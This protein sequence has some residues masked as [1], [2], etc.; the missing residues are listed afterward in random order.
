M[1]MVHSKSETASDV[2][3]ITRELCALVGER[4]LILSFVEPQLSTSYANASY[5]NHLPSPPAPDPM[6]TGFH[7]IIKGADTLGPFRRRRNLCPSLLNVEWL[8]P[9]WRSLARR[10]TCR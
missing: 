2:L 8:C 6:P 7:V 3:D 9:R 5:A 10:S 4:N 1:Q